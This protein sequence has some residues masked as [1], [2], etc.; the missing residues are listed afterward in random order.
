VS[1]F[2]LSAVIYNN[3]RTPFSDFLFTFSSGLLPHRSALRGVRMCYCPCWPTG[4]VGVS[5]TRRRFGSGLNIRCLCVE[6]R[7]NLL[8]SS[9]TIPVLTDSLSTGEVSDLQLN[10]LSV[11]I[12]MPTWFSL[13]ESHCRHFTLFYCEEGIRFNPLCYTVAIDKYVLE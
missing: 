7:P 8:G 3:L 6:D 5:P 1:C 13:P 12:A 11:I 9:K 4:H 2:F 10:S